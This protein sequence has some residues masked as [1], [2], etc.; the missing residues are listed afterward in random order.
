M[1]G[2]SNLLN[3]LKDARQGEQTLQEVIAAY[4]DELVTRGSEEVKCSV[5]N[6]RMLHDWEKVKQSPVFTNGFRPMKGH[7]TYGNSVK[8][9]DKLD[10][11]GDEKGAAETA[12]IQMEFQAQREG[13][14]AH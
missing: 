13:L 2:R 8:T 11:A 4:Q 9:E 1:F 3:A 12:A 10:S 5:E 14:A 6:G 7:D